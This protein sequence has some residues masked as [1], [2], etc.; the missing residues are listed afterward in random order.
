VQTASVRERTYL[1]LSPMLP[2]IM[3]SVSH[4]IEQF[5]APVDRSLDYCFKIF[6]RVTLFARPFWSYVTRSSQLS[7]CQIALEGACD[8]GTPMVRTI[9]SRVMPSVI[10]FQGFGEVWIFVDEQPA[11]QA[12]ASVKS[13]IVYFMTTVQRLIQC[14][15][16]QTTP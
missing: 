16:F 12:A 5:L 1:Y 10:A 13:V 6:V 15:I 4:K 11:R 7:L 2:M 8:V 3:A 14:S 9:S